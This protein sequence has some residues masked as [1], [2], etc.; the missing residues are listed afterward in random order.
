[1][2]W[3]TPAR[4]NDE[5]LHVIGPP[6]DFDEQPRDL[7]DGVVDLVGVVAGIGPHGFEPGKASADLVEHQA[8][9][10]AILHARG[11]PVTGGL[12]HRPGRGA[13]DPSRLILW[14]K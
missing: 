12:R 13:C 8:R 7:G 11:D 5:A 10:A 2:R 1:M 4:Q 9:A 6:D 3:T 14:A